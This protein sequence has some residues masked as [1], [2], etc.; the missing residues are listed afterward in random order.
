[1]K[2]QILALVIRLTAGA[3]LAM[4]MP[5]SA[6]VVVFGPDSCGGPASCAEG[7]SISQDWGD[8]AEVDVSHRSVTA[9]GNST[10]LA[11]RQLR[12]S[13]GGLYGGDVALVRRD[14]NN[15]DQHAEIR[16]DLLLPGTVTLH[17]V[18]LGSYAAMPD[19]LS[20]AVFDSDW[21]ELRRGGFSPNGP[22]EIQLELDIIS[23]KGLILQFGVASAGWGVRS[24]EYS[25]ASPAAIPEPTSWAMLVAGFAMIGVVRRRRAMPARAAV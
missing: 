4:A 3:A 23:S 20:Y 17:T 9:P 14:P 6:A 24:I 16:L 22:A 8:S 18:D 10:E 11:G 7:G 21:K 19:F 5:T 15:P 13:G 1:M 25:F 2:L 12:F